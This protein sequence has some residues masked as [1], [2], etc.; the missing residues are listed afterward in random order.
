MSIWEDVSLRSQPADERYL[1]YDR[2]KA[3]ARLLGREG[4]DQC[5]TNQSQNN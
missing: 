3:R 1:S 2:L 4:P 5:Q